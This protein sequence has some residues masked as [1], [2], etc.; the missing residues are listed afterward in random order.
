VQRAVSRLPSRERAVVR[1]HDIQ[2]VGMPRIACDFG[3]SVGRIS[4]LRIRA[5]GRL[6]AA[7]AAAVVLLIVGAARASAQSI[8]CGKP[9][10]GVSTCAISWSVAVPH[11]KVKVTLPAPPPI[12]KTIH[13]T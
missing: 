8:T 12:I 4:Q 5:L 2:G 3:V 9:V 10:N 13:D 7:L 6:R 11:D 1:R